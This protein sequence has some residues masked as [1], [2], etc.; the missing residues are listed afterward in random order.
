M[1]WHILNQHEKDKLMKQISIIVV[2]LAV[3]YGVSSLTNNRFFNKEVIVDNRNQTQDEIGLQTATVYVSLNS[4]DDK[5]KKE[6]LDMFKDF[7]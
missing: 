5:T 1:V 4:V 6:I 7:Q 3:V 2:L